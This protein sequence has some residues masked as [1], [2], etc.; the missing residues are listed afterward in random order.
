MPVNPRIPR[1]SNGL[2]WV[3]SALLIVMPAVVIAA[4]LQGWA[5]PAGIPMRFPGLPPETEI[6]LAKAIAVTVIDTLALIPMLT[7]LFQMRGLFDRYR[8]DEILSDT[9]AHHILRIGQSLLALAAITI[10]AP[11]LQLLLLTADNPDGAKILSIAVDGT[12]LGLVLAGALLVTIGWV[13]REAARAAAENA[14]FI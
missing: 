2:Y 14:E 12:M 13:M 1:L 11:T 10:G 6:T 8:H 4:L 3:S 7:M 9:C 5:A